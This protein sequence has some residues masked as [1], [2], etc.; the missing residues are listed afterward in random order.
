MNE[1]V[2]EYSIL[3]FTY[4]T[5]DIIHVGILVIR[6]ANY[7]YLPSPYLYLFYQIHEKMFSRGD[8]IILSPLDVLLNK[9]LKTSQ[10]SLDY[11]KTCCKTETAS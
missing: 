6:F 7:S 1:T 8:N 3:V 5:D 2:L 4:K 10:K 9:I 11:K